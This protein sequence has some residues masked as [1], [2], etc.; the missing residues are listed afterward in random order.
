MKQ[1]GCLKTE[2]CQKG[3]QGIKALEDSAGGIRRYG[4]PN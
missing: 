4:L 3:M 2:K 1:L